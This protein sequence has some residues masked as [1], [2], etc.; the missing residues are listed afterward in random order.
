MHEIT[1]LQD[2]TAAKTF[3]ISSKTDVKNSKRKE[4]QTKPGMTTDKG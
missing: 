4:V 2:V 3:F 1:A